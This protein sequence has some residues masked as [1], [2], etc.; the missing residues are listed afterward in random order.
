MDTD[1]DGRIPVEEFEYFM[2]EYGDR[3]QYHEE[4]VLGDLT[5][6]LDYKESVKIDS[7]IY[8]I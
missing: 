4:Q 7:L 1:G 3:L 2:R 6:P 8:K 5:K